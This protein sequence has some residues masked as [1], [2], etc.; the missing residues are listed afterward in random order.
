MKKDISAIFLSTIL[1]IV[2][3]G[4]LLFLVSNEVNHFNE[5]QN[6]IMEAIYIEVKGIAAYVANSIP[7]DLHEEIQIGDELSENFLYL[8]SIVRQ[9]SVNYPKADYIYTIKR[10]GD[11]FYFVLDSDEEKAFN[12]GEAI[13]E[14]VDVIPEALLLAFQGHITHTNGF[15]HDAWGEFISGYAP[16]FSSSGE[17][18]AVLAV[19]VSKDLVN[20]QMEGIKNRILTRIIII[21][22]IGFIALIIG[23]YATLYLYESH[24]VT[25]SAQTV[26]LQ[27]TN[28]AQGGAFEY[29]IYNDR[30]LCG[31]ETA[32]LFGYDI[33]PGIDTYALSKDFIISKAVYEDKENIDEVLSMVS[34]K[35]ENIKN[36]K[37][38]YSWKFHVDDRIK[39]IRF[40]GYIISKDE[41]GLK[42]IGMADDYTEQEKNKAALINTNNKIQILH[43]ISSHDI[44][45]TIT[46]IYAYADLILEEA[47]SD[48][49]KADIEELIQTSEA[50]ISTI[51]SFSTIYNTLGTNLPEW[52]DLRTLIN[53]IF[54]S[55]TF[56]KGI[57]FI[58][59]IDNVDL[60][61]SS[62]TSF[63]IQAL[64]EFSVKHRQATSIL[65][66]TN[67]SKEILY[68]IYEDD[69][70]PIPE[71]ERKRIFDFDITKRDQNALYIAKELLSV[72]DIIIK[73]DGT[74]KSGVHFVITVKSGWFRLRASEY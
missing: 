34:K 49:V 41:N 35:I 2:F 59:N 20:E 65:M 21:T 66:Y 8:N 16:I 63:V 33:V 18:V 72:T 14:T 24:R 11:F 53:E 57:K 23:I 6:L 29:D 38:T 61:A 7:G 74:E 15:Y 51:T 9:I 60:Y 44:R 39:A 12:P 25:K 54:H 64:F 48:Y 68:I 10:D 47:P 37:F 55:K 13:G 4:L 58:N 70:A 31:I 30:L 22:M 42:I 69:G 45:N 27:A 43:S 3:I 28:A 40:K 52:I 26:L 1:F 71:N 32:K 73:E 56:L 67:V 50:S 62:Q 46:A 17:V 19:D 5:A 36:K